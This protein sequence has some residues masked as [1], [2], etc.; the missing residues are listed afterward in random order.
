MQS[1]GFR[2]L[3]KRSISKTLVALFLVIVLVACGTHNTTNQEVSTK[4]ASAQSSLS[5]KGNTPTA[6]PQNST[7]TSNINPNAMNLSVKLGNLLIRSNNGFQCPSSSAGGAIVPDQLVLASNRTAYRTDEIAQM[8]TYITGNSSVEIKVDPNVEPPSTLRWVLGAPTSPMPATT[9]M[10]CKVALNLIN[11][12]TTSIQIPKIGVQLKARPQQNAYLYHLID[13]CSFLPHDP[14]ALSTHY[15]PSA[16]GGGACN[17]Y[18]ATI[19]LGPGENSEIFSA[20]PHEINYS[21]PGNP[22]CGILTLAP[23]A[24][25]QLY[26]TFSL[27]INTP[28]NLIY[29]ILPIFTVITAQ[30]AQSL[31]LPQLASTFAFA[32]TNQFSCYGLQGTTFVLEKSPNIQQGWCL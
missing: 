26:I 9:G 24:Q 4:T 19:Q 3:P 12:G 27:A 28:N 29:S 8:R 30:K 22:D 15:T 25:I 18:F 2:K 5:K 31:S 6:L 20:V 21:L 7:T 16:G 13:V 14:N 10:D 23:G 17:V 11:T 1:I 32:S